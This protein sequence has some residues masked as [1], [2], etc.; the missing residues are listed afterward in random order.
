MFLAN[1]KN[2]HHH[3]HHQPRGTLRHSGGSSRG[4]G[5]SSAEALE[6][7][8]SGAGSL[9]REEALMAAV[10]A[11]EAAVQRFFKEHGGSSLSKQPSGQG[12]QGPLHLAAQLGDQAV[13][14]LLLQRG[15]QVN[16]KDASGWT[17]LHCAAAEGQ[18]RMCLFL[19]DKGAAV[20]AITKAGSLPL[21][22]LAKAK[23]NKVLP[24]E[25]GNKDTMKRIPQFIHGTCYGLL[26]LTLIS[27]L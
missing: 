9:S 11:G 1:Q 3:N 8:F 26:L 12:H 22:Y 17:P 27:N 2:H 15:A 4:G 10:S 18:M 13:A 14:R 21:H 24:K 6:A 23:V 7:D 25:G 20:M 5:G 16:R 19:M